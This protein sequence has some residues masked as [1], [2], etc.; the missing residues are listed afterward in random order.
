MGVSHECQGRRELEGLH[1]CN[2]G[3][4]RET[5]GFMRV[6]TPSSCLMRKDSNSSP[7]KR[8]EGGERLVW[9]GERQKVSVEEERTGRG[10]RRENGIKEGG[11]SQVGRATLSGKG[12]KE[13]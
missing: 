3:L 10:N 11:K 6:Y 7:H 5:A 2:S 1:R 13:Q 12:R 9:G 4:S 8:K